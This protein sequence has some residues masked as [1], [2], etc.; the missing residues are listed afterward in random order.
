MNNLTQLQ[1]LLA[2]SVQRHAS[3]LY[4]T[5]NQLPMLRIDG[6]LTPVT[7]GDSRDVRLTPELI[8]SVLSSAQQTELNL[9]LEIDFAMTVPQ[10]GR[11]RVNA[12]HQMFGLAAVF[13]PLPERVPTFDEL[14]LPSV[15]KKIITLP[16]GLILVTGSTGAG[17]S[18]TLAAL[19]NYLNTHFA[20][21]IITLEDPIEFIH[22]PKQSLINQ[23]EL[24]RDTHDFNTALRSALRQ[25]PDV[26]L[27][28]EM[29]DL[30]TMRLALTA[31]EAGH[32]VLATLHTSSAVRT[33]NR[34]VDFF[35][36]GEKNNIRYLLA[37]ILQ[38][39]IYQMLLKKTTGGRVAAFEIMLATPAIQNLIRE[40]KI[41]QIQSVM[42]MGRAV[43]MCTLEQY[44]QTLEVKN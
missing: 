36:A 20:K 9:S 6:E 26:I 18:T 27:L 4:L 40:D 37:D 21:H 44:L 33:I 43:G 3:D 32:L 22:P 29:R 39:V 15:F 35:P 7:T 25:G 1:S 8:Y 16:H 14:N 17:K 34:I 31:A 38:A 12:F 28:G 30:P 24:P 11:F 13:R 10:V 42:Q 23:R 19:V 5:A 2:L 41:P